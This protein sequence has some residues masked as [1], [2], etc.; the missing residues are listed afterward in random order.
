[1][2]KAYQ[3]DNETKKYKGEIERQ[4]DP[5]ESEKQGKDVWLIPGD[6]TLVVPPE[7]KEGY[8]IFW[9]PENEE[10][11]YREK[12]VTPE[13][14]PYVPTEEELREQNRAIRN[15]YLTATDHTRLD[16]VPYTESEKELYKEYRQ[17][18]RDYTEEENWWENAPLE[19]EDWVVGHK[20][21][22]E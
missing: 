18:L 8:E 15:S 3:Y 21:V 19:F 14:E 16:D 11:E 6:S 9:V 2:P 20:P 12:P 7:E 5:L 1:M 4:R 13:P 10:W 22:S 17:Y